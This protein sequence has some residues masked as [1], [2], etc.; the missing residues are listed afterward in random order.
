VSSG[1]APWLTCSRCN[2]VFKS[3]NELKSCSAACAL[4]VEWSCLRPALAELP[5]KVWSLQHSQ[6]R[7]TPCNTYRL[8]PDMWLHTTSVLNNRPDTHAPG[9][10]AWQTCRSEIDL[11][12]PHKPVHYLVQRTV[13]E[14]HDLTACSTLNPFA[15]R[16]RLTVLQLLL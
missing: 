2:F 8:S 1:H 11:G 5:G 3:D 7:F 4:L 15:P 13:P 14:R 6:D 12:R 10:R 16:P 9:C